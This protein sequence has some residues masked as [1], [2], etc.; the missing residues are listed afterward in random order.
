MILFIQV[1]ACATPSYE[2]AKILLQHHSS[3]CSK[4]RPYDNTRQ[5]RDGNIALSNCVS[6]LKKIN[7][8]PKSNKIGRKELGKCMSEKE[9]SFLQECVGG[10]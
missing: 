7:I 4:S 8:K 1:G 6:E 5:N 3:G 9:F 10:N 2:K